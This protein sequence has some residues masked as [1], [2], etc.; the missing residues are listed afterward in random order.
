MMD[1]NSLVVNGSGWTVGA[2]YGINDSNQIAGQGIIGGQYH[3]LLLT[4]LPELSSWMTA[5]LGLISLVFV[6]SRKVSAP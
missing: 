3:A 2:A 6:R 4:P 1:L 5:A